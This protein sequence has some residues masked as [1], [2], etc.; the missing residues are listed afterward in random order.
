[1]AESDPRLDQI[2]DALGQ[3]TAVVGALAQHVALADT[4][5]GAPPEPVKLEL[6]QEDPYLPLVPADDDNLLRRT[7]LAQAL[8]ILGTPAGAALVN[9]GA[10]GFYRGLERDEGQERLAIPRHLGVQLVED[11]LLEDVREAG[12]MGLDLL[13][14]WDEDEDVAIARAPVIEAVKVAGAPASL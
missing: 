7:R 6:S 5:A 12:D 4:V 8:G 14:I 13:K 11:A 2:L 1:M 3:L 10:R 9:T